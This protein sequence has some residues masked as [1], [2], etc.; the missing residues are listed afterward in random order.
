VKPIFSIIIPV[1]NRPEEIDELLASISAQEYDEPFE[2]CIV[3]DGSSEKSDLIINKY[4]SELSIQYF[5]TENTGPGSSRNYGM[6]KATGNYFIIL[7]SDVILPN[8]YLAEITKQLE[9]KYTDAFGGPDA[10]HSSFSVLQ[11]AINYSMTSFLTT[12]GIRGNKKSVGKFQP[13]SFNMGL[14]QKAFDI[15]KGFSNMRAGEDIDLSFRLWEQGLETQLIDAA[16]VYHKRRN[17]FLGFFQQ[18][19]AFGAARP[20][21]NRMYPE[22]VKLTYWFPCIFIIGFDISI[23]LVI[24]GFNQ[25]LYFYGVYFLLIFLDSLLQ[26]KNVRVASLSIVTSFTQFLG[27]GL[28]FL[29]SQFISKK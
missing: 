12:G 3:E 7:D 22:T 4:T 9:K 29:E 26:N 18:T 13:R 27:Y 21:L 23:L 6:T 5:E 2:V 10:A 19:F 20:K 16:Y 25:L 17:S 15:T 8:N 28:G 1:Y 11:K 14:S 24:L